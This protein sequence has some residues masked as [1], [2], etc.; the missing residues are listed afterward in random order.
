[1]AD[2]TG[3]T[4][5]VGIL[6]HTGKKVVIVYMTLP[7]DDNNALVV[8]VDALPDSFNDTLRRLVESD[9]GQNSANLG[10]VLGR[11]PSPDG[12]GLTLLQKFHAAG[13]LQKVPVENVSMTP[14]AGLMWP[15]RG[16]LDAMKQTKD[17]I[18]EGLDDLDPETRA[19]V[20]AN[21]KKFNVH[22]SNMTGEADSNTRE[23]AAGLIKQ[24]EL[25]ESEA[26]NIRARAISLDPALAKPKKA[27]KPKKDKT[28]T[29]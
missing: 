13:R 7:G 23:Q 21:L 5:H 17:E 24:A 2:F 6:T 15:L 22:S 14:R 20:V 28:E 26:Q 4:K 29:L 25:L 10:D 18:P 11:R 16:V 19:Q 3:L 9:E 12:S 27:P 1:M 8:D